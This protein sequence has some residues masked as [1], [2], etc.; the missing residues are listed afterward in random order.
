MISLAALLQYTFPVSVTFSFV[1]SSLGVEFVVDFSFREDPHVLHCV[2]LFGLA[3]KKKKKHF[4]KGA[5]KVIFYYL[6]SYMGY[7]FQR[8]LISRIT[9]HSHYK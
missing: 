9:F 2:F 8:V 4:R 6:C 3:K 1:W 7:E 5:R